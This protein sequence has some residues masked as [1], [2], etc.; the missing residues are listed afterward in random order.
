MVE[1]LAQCP[2]EQRPRVLL[3]TSAAGYYG[4][5]GHKDEELSEEAPA[6][7]DF[8]AQLCVDWE[9]GAEAAAGHGVRVVRL[10]IGVVLGEGG[11]ALDK[12]V[13]AFRAF[14]GGPLGSGEQYVPWVHLD[15]VIGLM[16]LAMQRTDVQGALN[17][18]APNPV[19][20]RELARGLGKVLRRPAV[21][22]V[23]AT[24]LKLLLGEAAQALLGS[25]RVVPRRA[26]EI[27]YRFIHPE[28]VEALRASI[29][30]QV[31]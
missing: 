1:A 24:A 20:M 2:P 8:L 11:G 5:T 26:L 27:G 12:M 16:L 17:V 7:H 3:A 30:P 21:W 14:V 31:G 18:V 4:Y 13:P 6:G 10:R 29:D 25:Q 28:L 9:K 23:P 19:T 22:P 15:D